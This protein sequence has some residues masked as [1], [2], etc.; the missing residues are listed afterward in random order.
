MIHISKYSG[1]FLILLGA[2]GYVLT[3]AQSITALIPA[4][5]GIL[6]LILAILAKK[7]SLHRHM[8]HAVM[9][10]ALLGFIGSVSGVIKLLQLLGGQELARPAAAI[11]Q[12]IMSLICLTILIPGIKSFID[13]RKNK[14]V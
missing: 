7:D 2:A 10:I 4:F 12:A 8:M 5:F 14:T 6:I 3:G 9:V 13:A 11:S 1:F